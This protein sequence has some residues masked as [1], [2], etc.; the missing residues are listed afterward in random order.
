[1]EDSEIT[2]S[3][4][5]VKKELSTMLEIL[6][7]IIFPKQSV[8]VFGSQYEGTSLSGKSDIDFVYVNNFP[9]V[10]TNISSTSSD[11]CLLL[12]QN[13]HTPA[14]YAKLQLVQDGV[15]VYGNE[16]NHMERNKHLVYR[17]DKE[18]RLVCYFKQPKMAP[19]T[20]RH[21]PAMTTYVK[22]VFEYDTLF[23]LGCSSWP[24]SA[25]EWL[26]RI[27]RFD[28]PPTDLIEICKSLGFILVQKGHPHSDEQHLLWRLS[29]SRQ[30]RLLVTNFNSIQYKCYILLKL[31]KNEVL[32]SCIGEE[33]LTSYHCKTCMFFMIE[34]TPMDFWKADNIVDCLIACLR[35]ILQWAKSGVCPNYFI[36]EENMF[37]GRL[38]D[39]HRLKLSK[40]L[41]TILSKDIKLTLQQIQYDNIGECLSL[42][43]ETEKQKVFEGGN[44]LILLKHY[45]TMLLKHITMC[46]IRNM[47][48]YQEMKSNTAELG[49]NLTSLMYRIRNTFKVT[50]HTETQTK[51]AGITHMLA[52]ISPILLPTIIV[53]AISKCYS[54]EQI[55]KILTADRLNMPVLD[56]NPPAKVEVFKTNL[57]YDTFKLRQASIMFMLKFY[58]ASKAILLPLKRCIRFSICRCAV[59]K[60]LCPQPKDVGFNAG[61]KDRQDMAFDVHISKVLAPCVVFLPTQKILTP[62]PIIYEMVRS[63]GSRG[64]KDMWDYWHDWAVIDGQFLTH[65]LLYLNHT[66]LYQQYKALGDILQMETLINEREIS[67]TETC[68]NLLGW[69]YKEL[70][71]NEEALVCFVASL[72]IK[73]FQNAVYWHLCFLANEKFNDRN[74]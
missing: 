65:F 54:K 67:H 68:Y 47:I 59:H 48:L 51:A 15:P 14:G 27:R 1:M 43:S 12:I 70:G 55:W 74:E 11:D 9:K 69:A 6:L 8:Y 63:M 49:K 60:F 30:E 61:D 58:A 37:E 36:T 22:G 71:W 53:R 52:F 3:E 23:A 57:H 25:T 13:M 41:V 29:L 42:S 32:L 34:N 17:S 40:A 16:Y 62:V 5:D 44:E 2:V 19:E 38:S 35:K 73:P 50:D 45:P 39:H 4:R 10:V 26:T 21:G 7:S 33:T 64:E 28:W 24:A 31:I 18:N 56:T 66:M 72:N 46:G 20:E